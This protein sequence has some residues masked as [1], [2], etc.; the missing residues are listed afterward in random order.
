MKKKEIIYLVAFIILSISFMVLF[1][2]KNRYAK[3]NDYSV[4]DKNTGKVFIYVQGENKVI[5]FNFSEKQRKVT[6][7]SNT[8]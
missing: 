6:K 1:W 4:L 2:N 7:L 3:F 8:K 5:E